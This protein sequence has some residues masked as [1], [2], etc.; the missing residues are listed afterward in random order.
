[1]KSIRIG[2]K[3]QFSVALSLPIASEPLQHIFSSTPRRRIGNV[4][5]SLPGLNFGIGILICCG[6]PLLGGC[7]MNH[8]RLV[9]GIYLLP[10]QC[11]KGAHD[12]MA[13][14]ATICIKGRSISFRQVLK[15]PFRGIDL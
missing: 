6:I 11:P 9:Q 1:M 13:T 8:S 3:V 2:Q 15:E 7:C 12:G 10:A 5:V 14:F 4:I